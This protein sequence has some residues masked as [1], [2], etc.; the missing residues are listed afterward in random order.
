MGHKAWD[1]CLGRRRD[2]GDVRLET[3]NRI[4]ETGDG[5]RRRETGDR[6]QETGERR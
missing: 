3:W 4:S 5:D 2:T 6:R 1:R